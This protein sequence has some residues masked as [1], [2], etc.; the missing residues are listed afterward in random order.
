MDT[1]S[2]QVERAQSICWEERRSAREDVKHGGRK[3]VEL[4]GVAVKMVIK[5]TG[6]GKYSSGGGVFARTVVI[7]G[8]HYVHMCACLGVLSVRMYR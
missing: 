7:W 1:G 8:G 3:N 2:R 5:V 4:Y 6:D